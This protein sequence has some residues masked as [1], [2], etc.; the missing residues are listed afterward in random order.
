MVPIPDLWL[1]I[2]VA[3]VLVFV[4]SNVVWMALPHHKSDTKRLPDEASALEVIGKQGLAPRL[5]RYPWANSMAEM[6]DP[7]F[8]EKLNNV[9]VIMFNI[10]SNDVHLNECESFFH[11]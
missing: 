7:A 2:L 8:V 5:Y 10:A 4:A 9:F 11:G 3:T 1:P 6:K